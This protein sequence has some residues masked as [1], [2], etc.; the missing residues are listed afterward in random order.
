MVVVAVAAN[1]Q[2][3]QLI[4]LVAQLKAA[5]MVAIR[6]QPVKTLHLTL[7]AAAAAVVKVQTPTKPPARVA[8]VDRALS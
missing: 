5:A 6:E 8:R 2:I 3:Q 4:M 7:A 1:L